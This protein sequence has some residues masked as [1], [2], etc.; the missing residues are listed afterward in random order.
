MQGYRI[1]PM[2]DLAKASDHPARFRVRLTGILG[3]A[4]RKG[5][6]GEASKDGEAFGGVIGAVRGVGLVAA[7]L[8]AG[9]RGEV[10][11]RGGTGFGT[12]AEQPVCT[13]GYAAPTDLDTTV[14]AVRSL[15]GVQ[16]LWRIGEEG[17]DGLQHRRTIGLESE[18]VIAAAIGRRLRRLGPGMDGVAGDE[19]S[20]T[21]V[22]V[23][24]E[25]GLPLLQNVRASLLG[26]MRCL[27]CA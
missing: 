6:E 3:L 18:Q 22:G 24:L 11:H 14:V 15:E 1:W 4:L 27:F 20:G 19:A 7:R 10:R 16:R 21:E 17:G 12:V 26:G 2:T 8:D 23:A 5:V 13:M 9:E 25:P